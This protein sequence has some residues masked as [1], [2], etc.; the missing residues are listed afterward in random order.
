MLFAL[1]RFTLE[2]I[3]HRRDPESGSTEF[4]DDI[5]FMKAFW[6]YINDLY[7]R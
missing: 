4:I 7:I 1:Q 2:M 3:G 5:K 6:T